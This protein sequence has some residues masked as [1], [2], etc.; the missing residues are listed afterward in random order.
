MQL[1]IGFGT[2]VTNVWI[3][4]AVGNPIHGNP[5]G[6]SLIPT[7]SMAAPMAGVSR[8]SRRW[9]IGVDEVWETWNW[10]STMLRFILNHLLK[11]SWI[12]TSVDATQIIWTHDFRVVYHGTLVG[13]NRWSLWSLASVRWQERGESS[14]P[15]SSGEWALQPEVEGPIWLKNVYGMLYKVDIILKVIKCYIKLIWFY[16]HMVS[17]NVLHLNFDDI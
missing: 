3:R 13:N 12:M 2:N 15:G 11:S 14:G 5:F 8:S 4:N 7:L 10:A 9:R 17:C 16:R 1:F 6:S